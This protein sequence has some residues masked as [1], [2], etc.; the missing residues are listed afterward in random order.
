MPVAI[1]HSWQLPLRNKPVNEAVKP[2]SVYT[3]NYSHTGVSVNQCV[4]VVDNPSFFFFS[5]IVFFI[6]RYQFQV[7]H[8]RNFNFILKNEDFRALIE[9]FRKKVKIVNFK[10]FSIKITINGPVLHNLY[11]LMTKN[12]EH[13][14]KSKDLSKIVQ[15]SILAI[16]TPMGFHSFYKKNQNPRNFIF[17]RWKRF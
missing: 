4:S 6:C 11:N 12:Y 5:G 2:G 8:S 3:L 1:F 9:C 14:K 10:V 15:N 7:K 13:A 17:R 16:L